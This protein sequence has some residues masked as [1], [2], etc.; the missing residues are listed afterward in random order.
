MVRA[1]HAP[2]ILNAVSDLNIVLMMTFAAAVDESHSCV[3]ISLCTCLA[4]YPQDAV[5]KTEILCCTWY[6]HHV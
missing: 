5:V 3:L 1:D 2:V 4:N 6:T